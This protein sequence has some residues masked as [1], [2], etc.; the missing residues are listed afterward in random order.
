MR[1]RFDLGTVLV[2]LGAVLLLVSLFVD[3]YDPGTDAWG[4]FEAVDLL[5]A[6]CAVAGVVALAQRYEGLARAVPLLGF[7]VLVVVA[8]Q[9]IDPPPVVADSARD[10]GAW[11][12]LAGAAVMAVGAT[13]AAASISVTVDVHGRERR[14]RTSAIDA[15]EAA[16]APPHAEE[17]VTE[18]RPSRRRARGATAEPAAPVSAPPTRRSR[19][20]ATDAEPTETASAD[21]AADPERTQAL[22]PVER[23]PERP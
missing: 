13:L 11:L 1:E 20:K 16:P 18:T 6:A 22:D 7:T 12:A 4:V 23:P 10:T 8:T 21:V 15:R 5:L 14:R 19:P 17:S 9:L 2:A 3:W